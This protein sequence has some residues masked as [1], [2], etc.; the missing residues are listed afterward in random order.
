MRTAPWRAAALCLASSR[1]GI[2]LP[3][4]QT[5]AQYVG[6]AR[7]FFSGPGTGILEGTR[8]DG[9]LVRFDPATGYFG[10]MRNGAI[11]T[12]FRPDNGLAYFLEQFK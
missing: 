4:F 3:E 2:D 6:A 10:V 1:F 7:S 5:Y 12:F 11:S 9:A 8:A